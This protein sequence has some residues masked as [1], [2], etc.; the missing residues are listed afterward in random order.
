MYSNSIEPNLSQLK[1]LYN[2]LSLIQVLNLTEK[3]TNPKYLSHT[4]N[5]LMESL[6]NSM[7]KINIVIINSLKFLN[8]NEP[9][10]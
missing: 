9:K 4:Q 2:F 8:E 7:C 1:R 5:R 3:E 6:S 10:Y